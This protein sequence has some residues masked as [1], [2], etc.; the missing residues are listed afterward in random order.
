M[1]PGV[2]ILVVV[3]ALVWIIWLWWASRRHT[4][5]SSPLVV[6]ENIPAF[7]VV[8]LGLQGSGKTLLLA[9]MYHRLQTPAGQSYFLTAS[10]EDVLQ[11]NQWFSQMADTESANSWPPG[12]TKGE[13][14]HFSFTAKTRTAEGFRPILE[15]KYLEYAGELLTEPQAPG[16]TVQEDLFA[17]IRQAD[18]LLGIIDGNHIRQHLDGVPTGL[19]RL[20]Q[21][22][23]ALVP[24]M[25][26]ATCPVSF[27]ITKWDLLTG[28]HPDEST[29]LELVH[30]LLTS[31]DHFRSLVKI[32]GSG[33][34]VR[35]IPV[36]AVGSGFA[37]VDSTGRIVKVP[38]GTLHPSRVDVPLSAVVPDLFDQV[39][40]RLD[41]EARSAF[42]EEVRQRSRMTP[43]ETITSMGTFVGKAA[44]QAVFAAFGTSVTLTGNALVGLFLDS[45][46]RARQQSQDRLDRELTEAEQRIEDLR[47]ARRRVI[48]DMRRKVAVLEDQLPHSR[49]S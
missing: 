38:H 3:I 19:M 40:A 22:L 32:H 44:G 17:H 2:V 1:S 9:S 10:H 43:M 5:E 27:V 48:E 28:L 37:R 45:H 47:E 12:T 25:I 11:L 21:T 30:D 8:A 26:E 14:R 39:E 23:D 7:Q 13:S 16:S 20:E 35:L 4:S 31:N 34:V 41:K 6:E 29:R 36:S 42:Y 46:R 15:L 33:R 18:A 24:A 49:L